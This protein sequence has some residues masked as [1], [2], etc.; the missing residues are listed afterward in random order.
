MR[1]KIEKIFRIAKNL[2]AVLFG[3][4]SV[5]QAFVSWE[6]MAFTDSCDR[7]LVLLCIVLVVLILSILWVL[8]SETECVWKRGSSKIC[9]MYGDI[10]KMAQRRPWYTRSQQQKIIVIPVNTHFDTIVDDQTVP[11][12]L[13]SK[14]TIHG[15]WLLQYA[16]E[17]HITPE[18]IEQKI[19]DF[20]DA[21]QG[22]FETVDRPRGSH[23]NY[24]AGTCAMLQGNNN[25]SFLL[26]ALSEFDEH[27]TAHATKEKLI[28]IL[29]SLIEFINSQSQGMDC[30]IPLLGTGL[31]R[32]GLTHKES[33][34]T[35][36]STLDLY[37]DQNI[38]KITVVVYGGDKSNV[39]IYD[40]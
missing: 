20:L 38:G 33:L 10:L 2:W 17:M 34:H 11:N 26:L 7:L 29:H 12:P 1:S 28:S 31:S 19:F 8:L 40:R 39:S 37:N 5:M 25:T 9:V 36:L 22:R 27:N 13:V 3:L 23:R 21:K 24:V 30:Y 15:K 16:A 6:D 18:Q 14:K 32:T 4:L 35:I